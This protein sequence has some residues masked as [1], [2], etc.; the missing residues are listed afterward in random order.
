MDRAAM[1]SQLGG[2]VHPA[3]AWAAAGLALL[4][5]IIHLLNRRRFRRVPWAAMHFLMA[6]SRR[7]KRRVR[8][9]QFILLALRTLAILFIAFALA[10]PYVASSGLAP[11]TSSRVQRVIILDDSLSMQATDG[12]NRDRTRY[13]RATSAAASLIDTFNAADPVTLIVLAAPADIALRDSV[14]RRQ[15]RELL[16]VRTCSQ[17]TTDVAGALRL[18]VEALESTDA[19]PQNRAVYVLSD[20]APAAW[21]ESAVDAAQI[22]VHLG[23]IAAASN[24]HVINCAAESAANVAITDFASLDR[25]IGRD[26]SPRLT[27]QVHNAGTRPASGLR[28]EVLLS[29]RIVRRI[30]LSTIPAGKSESLLFTIQ[31][32][33]DD[34]VLIEA[35]IVSSTPDHLSVDDRRWLVLEPSDRIDVLVVEGKHGRVPL[36]GD[37]GY[38]VTAM[39]PRTAD[40]PDALFVPRV[41]N[42]LELDGEALDDY[43]LVTLCNVPRLGASVWQRLDR[44]VQAGGGLLV[45]LGPAVDLEHY[46][47]Y[48][49]LDAAGPLP[50]RL[51]PVTSVG[52]S[53]APLRIA[54]RAS[55]LLAE[56][57]A[58]PQASLFR[59]D[60][61]Q[62]IRLDS[63]DAVIETPALLAN[64]AP[65]FLTASRGRG[66]VGLFATSMDMSWTNLPAKGDFVS[67]VQ[68]IVRR[69]ARS[70]SSA[71]DRVVGEPYVQ[72]LS[73][74]QMTA[75]V[76]I[77]DP[78]G[79]MLPVFIERDE[80]HFRMTCRNTSSV[81]IYRVADAAGERVFAV[82]PHP[83]ESDL[84]TM[85]ESTLTRRF[86]VEFHYSRADDRIEGPGAATPVTETARILAHIGL[87]LLALEMWAAMRFGEGR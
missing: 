24:L 57:V 47:R 48:A 3:L 69:L 60:V 80:P 39:A 35:R 23:R 58:L 73:P 15:L 86:P 16:N 6:A 14:D 11:I 67:L 45:A 22:Q 1:I 66:Q 29:G 56:F 25:V 5:I 26:A 74:E 41:I 53:A 62:H 78:S 38:L 32:A 65:L 87:L 21:G 4:P 31:P 8:I 75:P 37:A 72:P 81:G 84:R 50:A 12:V 77:N 82:N 64:G 54:P 43:R 83:S 68:K 9:E 46:N 36:E 71:G 17:R 55:D 52:D 30:D 40:H 85:D 19:P 18:A 42:D 13:D 27:A 2:F 49:H 51:E 61:R 10:R 28:F 7:S 70:E 79:K 20:F 76:R 63:G 44:Y 33:D 59:A 34:Q